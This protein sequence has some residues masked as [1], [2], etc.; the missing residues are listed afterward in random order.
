MGAVTERNARTAGT[1]QRGRRRCAPLATLSERALADANVIFS[2]PHG[3][4]ARAMFRRPQLCQSSPPPTRPS[5]PPSRTHQREPTSESQPAPSHRPRAQRPNGPTPTARRHL[6][7]ATRQ[8]SQA[9]PG[10]FRRR[11][12]EARLTAAAC[13]PPTGA[14]RPS[15]SAPRQWRPAPIQLAGIGCPNH[16]QHRL[17]TRRV[18]LPV[19]IARFAGTNR[20]KSRRMTVNPECRLGVSRRLTGAYLEAT[21][22]LP[23]DWLPQAH[24]CR[25]R[26]A[27]TTRACPPPH[28]AQRHHPRWPA[29]HLPPQMPGELL[30]LPGLA[31]TQG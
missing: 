4:L 19:R 18:R 9:G 3:V 31:A 11:Q 8:P 26:L 2:A 7:P 30:V 20:G 22:R 5:R 6:A 24:D 29:G 1:A 25:S 13:R 15:N 10:T 12:P 28:Q 21:A 14:P 23:R 27:H 16:R 17:F